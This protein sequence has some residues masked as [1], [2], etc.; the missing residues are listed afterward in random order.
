MSNEKEATCSLLSPRKRQNGGAGGVPKK[1]SRAAART[2]FIAANALKLEGTTA[3]DFKFDKVMVTDAVL[4]Y[5]AA[6]GR[7]YK[8]RDERDAAETEREFRI[9]RRLF[10][11]LHPAL[12][13][14]PVLLRG[15]RG[16]EPVLLTGY[17]ISYDPD[18]QNLCEM[19]RLSKRDLARIDAAAQRFLDDL[20]VRKRAFPVFGEFSPIEEGETPDDEFEQFRT[21][22]C[23][24]HVDRALSE[25]SVFCA[26][27]LLEIPDD[28]VEFYR[29]QVPEL[30]QDIVRYASTRA[31]M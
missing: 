1:R 8:L 28:A 24:L 16:K 9:A 20:A 25:M 29:D 13:E 30:A 4:G 27:G 22:F 31:A 21:F 26:G 17:L 10:P 12:G 23:N 18:S 6:M 7:M 5:D 2:E 14:M 15:A 11:E 3:G 19:K